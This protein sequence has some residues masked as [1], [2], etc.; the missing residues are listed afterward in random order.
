[1][2]VIE[3]ER[4]RQEFE[5]IVCEKEAIFHREKGNSSKNNKRL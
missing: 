5:K 1:M 2:Q 4:K 3:I